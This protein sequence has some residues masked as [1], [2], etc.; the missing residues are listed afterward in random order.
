M[1]DEPAP[2][3]VDKLDS[4][5]ELLLVFSDNV[6]TAGNRLAI[7]EFGL[8]A[9]Q[10]GQLT[11]ASLLPALAQTAVSVPLPLTT[12]QGRYHYRLREPTRRRVAVS[13]PPAM[14]LPLAGPREGE[15]LLRLL[16]A[17][18]ALC[19]EGETG[20]GE[21][22]VSSALHRHSRWR[23]G[24]FVA[25]NCAAIPESLIESELFGY[26]AR[27]FTGAS[28][29]G[30]IG[31]IREGWPGGVLFLDEIGDM[32]PWRCR[33]ASCASCR[34]KRS[35]RWAPAAAM[36]VNFALICA[37]HRNLTQ[38]VSAGRIP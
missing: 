20:G 17:S 29:N 7:R 25:I 11:F 4:V 33:P 8:S 36:P 19:I 5:E 1:A 35:L 32:P 15:K 18:V 10:F 34:R 24:K 23:S 6:L 30:Y 13:A 9:A 38:R 14:H 12:P 3:Q 21:E 26:L 31:K 28:K 22:Y 27:A 2:A 16:S 37:T